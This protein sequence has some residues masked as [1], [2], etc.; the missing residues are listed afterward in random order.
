MGGIWTLKSFSSKG[1]HH[2]DFHTLSCHGVDGV[3]VGC[4]CGQ[5]HDNVI[6]WKHFPCYWPFVRG[7]HRS[8][9]NSS[10]KGQWR[11]AFMFSLIC[12]W[13]NGWVNNR[14]SGDLRRHRTHY[15]VI[16]MVTVGRGGLRD[17]QWVLTCTTVDKFRWSV[18]VV[19]IHDVVPPAVDLNFK[20]LSLKNQDSSRKSSRQNSICC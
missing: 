20:E 19:A 7:I 8:P 12:A 11:G 3:W 10:H 1:I 4:G 14:K 5:G 9:V 15:D 2:I 6:K 18:P 16:V 13:I 17:I